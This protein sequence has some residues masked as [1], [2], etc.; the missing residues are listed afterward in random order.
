MWVASEFR[1]GLVEVESVR[2]YFSTFPAGSQIL[3]DG[4]L[5]ATADGKEAAGTWITYKCAAPII[6]SSVKLFRAE[7][8]GI[9]IAEYEVVGKPV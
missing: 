5:C 7:A 4:K 8:G 9:T 6:G 1:D 3:I 2:V